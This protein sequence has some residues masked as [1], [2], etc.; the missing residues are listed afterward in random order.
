MEILYLEPQTHYVKEKQAFDSG[1]HITLY[2]SI[3]LLIL[4][5]LWRY[6]DIL[7]IFWCADIVA[8][9]VYRSALRRSRLL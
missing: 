9:F 4:L 8:F 3:G 7:N 1:G 5:L 6:I 2:V